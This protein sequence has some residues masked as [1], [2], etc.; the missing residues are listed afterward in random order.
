VYFQALDD[1]KECVGI[2]YNGRLVFDESEF[3]KTFSNMKTWRYSGFLND[4]SIQYGW[5]MAEGKTLK[6]C[7]PEHL[8]SDL[9]KFEKKM[10]AY[11]KAFE[12]AR[13]NF[14]EH[15]FFDLVP[16]DFLVSFLELKNQVT[17]HIFENN[18]KTPL[19]DHLLKVEKL[20]YK[21]RYQNL[22]I[23]NQNARGL[24]TS[25]RNRAAA[26]K[27]LS[28]PKHIDY[29]IFGT[30]TGRLSTYTGSFPILTMPKDLRVLVKPQN[31]WFISLDYN[32][33]EARTVLGLLGKK[34]PAGDVHEWNVDNV[35]RNRGV[36]SREAA[37][38]FFFSWLYNPDSTKI[39]ESFYDR[40]S[41]LREYYHDG[42]IRTIFDRKIEV[43]EYKA[44]NYIVQSTTAD[45]VNDRA[46]AIDQFLADKQ[47]FVSYIVH[48]EIVLDM[49]DE[50]R[51]LIPEIKEIFSNN[52]LDKFVTN[53]KAGK[54]YMDI[55]VLNL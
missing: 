53:L 19:Y 8:M 6:E 50:E 23:N 26:Q 2:Y 54:D 16:H 1:K 28:G 34:Q 35:F 39:E 25:S 24:F 15:C 18:E 32:G 3:P 46:V 30:R 47:T 42:T 45:L 21:I 22:N 4:E 11:K 37:K 33:A 52:K 55:G 10:N 43:E 31:D 9:I 27:L 7:C 20:L 38:T 44:I 36:E 41:L 51:Y 40:D 49:P 29:N 12:L 5:L 17:Q 14:R 13:I 48:D